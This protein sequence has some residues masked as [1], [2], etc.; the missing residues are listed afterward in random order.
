MARWRFLSGGQYS[1]TCL[2]C[3]L[4]PF[5]TAGTLAFD[6]G[7]SQAVELACRTEL[8]QRIGAIKPDPPVRLGADHQHGLE[9]P[10]A[11]SEMALTCHVAI[12]INE[13]PLPDAFAP[14]GDR[15]PI[16]AAEAHCPRHVHDR[17][18]RLPR[19]PRRCVQGA[20]GSPQPGVAQKSFR[21]RPLVWLGNAATWQP[22]WDRRRPLVDLIVEHS[23]TSCRRERNQRHAWGHGCA[24]SPACEIPARGYKIFVEGTA[25]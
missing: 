6:Y 1:A 12:E 21:I 11:A 13:S 17:L 14:R 4:D 15:S 9:T 5:D 24:T 10:S 19:L 25:T 8:L 23:H 3:A 20:A 22:A 16:G 2:A 18:F 7:Q